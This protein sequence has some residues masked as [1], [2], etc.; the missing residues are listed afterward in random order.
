MSTNKSIAKSAGIIGSATLLSRILGFTRDIIF[1]ALF[2]TGVYAQAFVV[3]FRIPNLLRDLIG[4]GATNA[5]VVPVLVEELTHNGRQ[6]FLKLANIL[7]NLMLIILTLL[8]VIGVVFSKP[9]VMA[10]AP[11]FIADPGKFEITVALTRVMFPYLIFVGLAA[12]GMGVLNSVKHFTAPALGTSMLNISLII[13]MFLWR[14]DVAG[15]AIGVLIGGLLQ[16][17]IQIPPLL[18]NGLCF[19]QRSIL[20]PRVKKIARLLV[21]RIFGSGV[22]QINVFVSTILASIGKVAG[23]GAIAALY[24]SNRILQFPLAIFAIALAQAALPTL[25]EHVANKEMDKFRGSINF[26]LR[27]VAFILLPSSA[28]LIAL[29]QP[30]TKTLLER[31]AFGLYSTSITSSALF[32]Y[33][34]G[35]FAY[36][37]IKILVGA[38]YSMQDTSTPVKVAA[39]SLVVNIVLNVALMYPL[40]VGGLAL[41]TSIAG[42]LNASILFVLLRKRLGTLDEKILFLSFAKILGASF[43]MG[44]FTF[45]INRILNNLI[46]SSSIIASVFILAITIIS[47]I[48]FYM[49]LSYILKI[50]ELRELREWILKKK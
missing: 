9:I 7:L 33:A 21:P 24:F 14:Q 17:L 34:F 27:G 28:G 4:E 16:I 11:G 45:Y 48:V 12:Y 44:L 25:S 3:A 15:L 8:T 26:L 40:K 1:A 43:L 35:L 36:G 20:H 38:F 50:R 10:I 37:A 18:K 13:C 29:S 23:E 49:G 31:G 32:F 6:E 42:I 19:D 2:G 39:F 47:S 41:A 5:A 22:Y 46:I 30:I